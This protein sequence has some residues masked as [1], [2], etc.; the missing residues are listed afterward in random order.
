M[1]S[2]VGLAAC[3]VTWLLLLAACGASST[4]DTS[5]VAANDARREIPS[6]Y[7]AI[8]GTDIAAQLAD[9]QFAIDRVVESE[10]AACMRE[11][12]FRYEPKSQA[13]IAAFYEQQEGAPM[14]RRAEQ[15]LLQFSEAED[16]ETHRNSAWLNALSPA[17]QESWNEAENR[18][19]IDV[20]AAHEN[21]LLEE[22]SWYDDA[23]AAASALTAVD[24][25]VTDARRRLTTCT[26]ETGYGSLEE[27]VG[28]FSDEVVT[29]MDDYN[30]GVVQEQE[31]L[32]ALTELAHEEADAS[33]RLE[34]CLTPYQIVE[35]QVYAENVSTIAA[36]E[37]DRVALWAAEI[38]EVIDSY[39]DYLPERP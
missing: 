17:E 10:V 9:L 3:G 4:D 11:Q 26:S 31:A 13:E 36:R 34:A 14:L 37:A 24:P 5:S 8:L 27:A 22:E 1:C 28:F 33:V 25:R 21:P 20:S 19:F 2:R 39:A 16:E 30:S 7:V 32:D 12:G 15:A 23:S 6:E 38:E 18:C 29:I 35:R